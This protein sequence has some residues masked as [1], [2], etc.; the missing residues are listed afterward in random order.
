MQKSIQPKLAYE[1][2]LFPVAKDA[3]EPIHD[4]TFTNAVIT[5]YAGSKM[6]PQV[7]F[8]CEHSSNA[9]PSGYKWSLSDQ[10][11]FQNTHWAI[12]IGALKLGLSIS[13]D[14]ETAIC[15]AKYSRL[16]CDVNRT[17]GMSTM[18]RKMGDGL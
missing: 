2:T 5:N 6:L 16:L 18:F 4:V 7:I 14:L 11:N 8:T 12:D 3:P 9:L 1:L 17:P 10:K 13:L 15:W